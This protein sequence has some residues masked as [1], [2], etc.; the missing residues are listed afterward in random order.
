MS[1][2]TI[3]V[4]QIQVHRRYKTADLCDVAALPDG[5]DLL[6]LFHGLV[7]DAD[8]K[9]LVDEDAERY[10]S[11]E[12]ISPQGRTLTLELAVGRFG[13]QG[14][15]RNVTT[16]TITH[17]HGADEAHT[18]ATRAMLVVPK[19][20][21]SAL[22]FIEH[23]SNIGGGTALLRLLRAAWVP[24][25]PDWTLKT[26]SLV[27]ADAWLELAGLE[28]ITA[29]VYGWN[30]DTADAGQPKVVGDLRQT[31]EPR[32]GNKF[33]PKGVWDALR[34]GT[35]SRGQLLGL[36]D[37]TEPDEVKVTL[38]HDGLTKTFVLGNEKTP[39]VRYAFS[40]NGEPAPA[41]DDFRSFC[42]DE[43]AGLLEPLEAEWQNSWGSGDWTAEQLAVT[44]D[45]PDGN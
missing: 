13:D 15:N 10:N 14:W 34:D 33:F 23:A 37:G 9:H 11:V 19:S 41:T 3:S 28:S 21:T 7:K 24:R 18:V 36:A 42:L 32:K 40:D 29:V 30:S 31:I 25:Y 38:E 6:H 44:M 17:Q 2:R 12:T 26:S 39:P 20:G 43:I 35:I 16:H 22:L 8:P 45:V 5:A 27:E 1:R 4:T